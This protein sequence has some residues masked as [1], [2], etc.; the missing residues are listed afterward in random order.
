MRYLGDIFMESISNY[1]E[2]FPVYTNKINSKSIQEYVLIGD[3]CLKIGG[4][5]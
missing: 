1:I 5:S 3:P 4:Y 2:K